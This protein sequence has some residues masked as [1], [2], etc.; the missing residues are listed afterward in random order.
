ML[1]AGSSRRDASGCPGA[2]DLQLCISGTQQELAQN[3][4]AKL[5]FTAKLSLVVYDLTKMIIT[6]LQLYR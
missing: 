2:L 4:R 3:T 5:E 1:P 6:A